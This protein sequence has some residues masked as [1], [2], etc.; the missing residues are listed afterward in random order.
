MVNVP[1]SQG[2]LTF[3]GI[4]GNIKASKHDKTKNNKHKQTKH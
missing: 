1:L 2:T 3:R 4:R